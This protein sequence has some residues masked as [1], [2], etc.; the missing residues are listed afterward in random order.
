[1]KAAERSGAPEEFALK[2]EPRKSWSPAR[3]LTAVTLGAW[4]GL[5][6]FLL[7]GDRTPL[8][9]STRTDW[10]VP[11]GAIILTI[12]TIGRLATARVE[13]PPALTRREAWGAGVILLPVVAV[14]ALPPTSLGSFAADRRSS[15]AGAG[16][17]TSAEQ[18]ETGEL[19]LVDVI[20]AERDR[21]AMRAL[22]RRAGTEVSFV[23]FVTRPKSSP[24]DE[25]VLTR[26][27]VSCCVADALAVQVRVVGAPP[28]RFDPD[29]WVRVTG[30]IYPL[31]SE[32]VVQA[33]EVEGT[34]RPKHP[35]LNP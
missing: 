4:C 19:T 23:G 18:I 24:A 7:L 11:L 29:D 31:G 20:G 14:L 3:V 27:V 26:F 1:M 9:L 21:E 25:F 35:Y 16:F 34:A 2:L 33:S 10:V 17:T 13:R 15:F 12:A 32:I 22:A 6:W 28:G 8:Y 30:R 5:F